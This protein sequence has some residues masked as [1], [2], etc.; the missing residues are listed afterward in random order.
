MQSIALTNFVKEIKHCTTPLSKALGLMFTRQKN[1]ALVFNFKKN[2][3]V[4]LHMFF[5]F[6]P[7]D[8]VYLDE[9]KRVIALKENFRPFTFYAP[10]Q[11]CRYVIELPLDTINKHDLELGSEITF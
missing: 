6:Y 10:K 7:I 11:K 2:T 8:V 3:R 4:S 5:V 1:K 9:N